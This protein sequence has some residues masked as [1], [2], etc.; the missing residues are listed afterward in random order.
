[1]AALVAVSVV[2]AAP[3]DHI[4]AADFDLTNANG[5]AGGLAFDGSYLRVVDG[6]DAKAYA[7]TT[8]GIYT[9]AEDISLPGNNFDA[10]SGATSRNGELAAL[11]GDDTHNGWV[12]WRIVLTGPSSNISLFSFF[13]TDPSNPGSTTA[14]GTGVA[15]DGAYFRTVDSSGDKVWSHQT[16]GTHTSSA[17]FDLNV[18]NGN[19][20]GITW[21]GTY[22]RVVDS[23][24]DKVYSY[25]SSGTYTSSADFDLNV[26][27]GN[28]SGI[29]WDGTYYRVVDSSDGKVYTYEGSTSS[30]PTSNF[31][32]SADNRDYAAAVEGEISTYGDWKCLRSAT[33]VTV[34]VNNAELTVNGFC[35]RPDGTDGMQ[36]E[37]HL[38]PLAEHNEL[39]RFADV[40]GIWWFIETGIPAQFDQR[41]YD[42]SFTTEQD[43]AADIPEDALAF[44]ESRG[45]LESSDRLGFSTMAKAVSDDDCAQ[46][47]DADSSE[48]D[49]VNGAGFTCDRS[50]LTNMSSGDDGVLL[51]SLT[52]ENQVEFADAPTIPE[53]LSVSRSA[54]Y[55]T[56]TVT[57]ELYDAVSAYELQRLTAVQV[58]VADASRIEY[59]DP[60]T[61]TIE[62]TQAGIDEYEDSTL[63]AHR[64]YQY[65]H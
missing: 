8:A 41:I 62:G 34:R 27:N 52:D 20:S 17:D 21:D 16:D 55:A 39:E 19:P 13:A 11:Q 43:D 28:P 25:N 33:G 65:R 50:N 2:V 22:Y 4:S 29:T 6:N 14:N 64:T 56:A 3:G 61:V 7:Y 53:S 35:A 47:V 59:G 63:E 44:T 37:I 46:S 36:V 57:W 40:T 30:T 26:D 18:D 58:D 51:F 42:D 60:V 32:L 9:S 1:M 24:D 45:G 5:S 12:R 23:S 49:V 10:Y 54:D 31:G 38:P 48:A 15:W